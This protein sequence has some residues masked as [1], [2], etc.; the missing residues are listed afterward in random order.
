MSWILY[1]QFLVRDGAGDEARREGCQAVDRS[2]RPWFNMFKCETAEYFFKETLGLSPAV[3]VATQQLIFF[4]RKSK[5]LQLR[6]WQQAGVLAK[7]L[8]LFLCFQRA[9][10][11]PHCDVMIASDRRYNLI[12]THPPRFHPLYFWLPM[13]S[14]LLR[15]LHLRYRKL[16]V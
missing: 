2:F 14:H 11:F 8:A 3:F 12:V 6:L 7:L 13:S 4:D 16:C 1:F 5:Y 9:S 15:W 10:K